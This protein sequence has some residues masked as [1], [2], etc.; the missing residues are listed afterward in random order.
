MKAEE[1]CT[2]V[3]FEAWILPKEGE[4]GRILDKL[5]P[6]KRDGFLLD[7]WPKMSLRL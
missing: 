7:C 2:D 5:T 4:S 6:G 1:L 3:S